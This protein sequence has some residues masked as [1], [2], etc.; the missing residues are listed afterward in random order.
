[1]TMQLREYQQRTID[2][3]YALQCKYPHKLKDI[4][5]MGKP[6]ISMVGLKSHRWTVLSE[7]QKPSGASQTGKFWNCVCE[8]GTQRVVYGETIR[9]GS[10]KSC[11]CLKAEKSA[12]AMKKMRL[13]QSGSLQDRF[14][15]RFVKLENGCWQWRAHTDKD[16][17]GILPGANQN[18]R[19]HR[20]SYEIHIGEIPK[21]M[22]VCH[23]CDN[24]GCVNPDHLFV[25]T[26]KDNAHDALQKGRHYIGE[27]NGRSKLTV[28]KAKEILNSDMNGQK[29]ADKFGV[30]RSTINNV[31]RG[32]TWK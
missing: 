23:H 31:K 24:P 26:P 30:N 15:S 7:A 14:F 9:S 21:E 19:S 5:I 2:Q 32:V 25:G 3:L 11:G 12:V 17:Y 28:E 18:T 8:C 27:K 6:I 13:R 16:G 10:S 1:M 22:I 29:L 4:C 20:L